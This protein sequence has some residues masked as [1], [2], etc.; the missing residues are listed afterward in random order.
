MSIINN[1]KQPLTFNINQPLY[2]KAPKLRE[3]KQ[4]TPNP[5]HKTT[6]VLF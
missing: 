2:Q 3:T 1:Q 6:S 4:L 5:N